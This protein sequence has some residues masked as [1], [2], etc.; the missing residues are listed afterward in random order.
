MSVLI[1]V[2]RVTVHIYSKPIHIF[3]W[4]FYGGKV[5][6]HQDVK[7]CIDYLDGDDNTI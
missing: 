1:G 4:S 3:R 5:R 2:Q 7:Y 6:R